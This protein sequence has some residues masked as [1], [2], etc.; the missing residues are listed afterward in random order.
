M[1]PEHKPLNPFRLLFS[2]F[3]ADNAVVDDDVDD[4]SEVSRLDLGGAIGWWLSMK[5]LK[6]ALY[7]PKVKVAS[8]ELDV[9]PECWD[10]E[11]EIYSEGGGLT[12]EAKIEADALAALK[13]AGGVRASRGGDDFGS[14]SRSSVTTMRTEATSGAASG[15]PRTLESVSFRFS[16]LVHLSLALSP[17]TPVCKR[18]AAS[19]SDLLKLATS[20]SRLLSLSL[21]HWPLPSLTPVAA[22]TYAA[23]KNPLSTTL[24]GISY[25]GS[26]VYTSYDGDWKEAANLLKILSRRLYCLQW[27]DFTGC[28]E[29]FAALSAPNSAEWTGAWRSVEYVGLGVGWLPDPAEDV[30]ESMHPSNHNSSMSPTSNTDVAEVSPRMHEVTR[31]ENKELENERK[32]Y[33]HRKAVEKYGEIVSTSHNV[34]SSVHAA[35]KGLGRWIYFDLSPELPPVRHD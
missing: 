19:W 35:R 11:C 4:A 21:A 18:T 29:W 15:R 34:A 6:E 32:K 7:A 2:K 23:I 30:S 5:E 8:K 13:V 25:G 9:V 3:D 27:L 26:D 10:D 22:S 16:N 14:E 24:P 20:L 12:G 28:G 33:Y 31:N 17:T 1:H